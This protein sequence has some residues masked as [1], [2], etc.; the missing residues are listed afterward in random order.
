MK[1]DIEPKNSRG[2]PKTLQQYDLCQAMVIE[3]LSQSDAGRKVGYAKTTIAKKL[4]TIV[5]RMAPYMAHLSVAKNDVIQKNFDI[6]V[7]R[8]IDE[9]VNMGF[10]NPKDYIKVVQYRGV[11]MCIGKPLNELTDDQARVVSNW[12]RVKVVTDGGYDF[13]YQYTF[14]DKRQSLRDLGQNMGMYNE[15]LILEQRITKTYKVDLSGVPDPILEKWMDELKSHAG[16]LPDQ[17][18]PATID[19]D[20]GAVT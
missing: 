13:D 5:K 2:W 12:E 8:V 1:T 15:K 18:G 16:K 6:T 20:S 3:G 9:L 17:S 11:D 14:Y 19:H 7:D 10:V 4:S